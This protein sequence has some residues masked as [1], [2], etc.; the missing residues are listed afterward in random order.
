VALQLLTQHDTLYPNGLLVPERE[1]LAIDAL[2]RLGR[3][4]EAARRRER[5]EKRY[6][7]SFRLKNPVH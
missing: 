6:P 3:T 2:Q 4:A 5:F 7:D 1:V